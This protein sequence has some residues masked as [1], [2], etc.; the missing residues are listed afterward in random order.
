ML[1]SFAPNRNPMS[2]T[3]QDILERAERVLGYRFRDADMLDRALTHSSVADDY[4]QSNERLE[5]LGD[6][7]LGYVVCEELFKMFPEEHEGELTKI[8]SAVVS[9]RTCAQISEEIGLSELLILG[10][11][12]HGDLP[13]SLAAGVY[14]SIVA[15]I[16]LDGGLDPARDFILRTM[17][18]Q[19]EDAAAS[20]HQ[21]NFKSL[22]QQHAQKHMSDLPD[23]LLLDEKGPDHAKCFEVCVAIEGRRF[24]SAWGQSKK[25]AEQNAA[26]I[27]LK[28]LGLVRI[29]DQEQVYLIDDG[30]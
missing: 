3:S 12:M 28:E 7:I 22:L 6:A 20:A 19:I 1:R 15:G 30:D 18:P 14:E 4:L 27:A 29:D 2:P 11:G 9:R 5:F 10:K 24:D 21:Q 16:Y 26:L 8:K 23:Y 13:S 17:L 25:Q